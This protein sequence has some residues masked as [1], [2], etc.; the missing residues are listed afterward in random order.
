MTSK[1][2]ANLWIP[3]RKPSAHIR[4]RLFCFPYAG[5][6]A[7]VFRNWFN[8]FPSEIDICP[9]QYPGREQRMNESQFTSLP[10]LVDTL[11]EALLPELDIPFAFFG[12]SLG[13]LISFELA[14]LLQKK[15]ITPINLFLSSYRAPTIQDKE[16]PSYL[17]PDCEFVEKL[18]KNNGTPASVL[19]NRE[20]MNL[21]LPTI[22]GDFSI[23]E[24]YVYLPS[25]PLN[26]PI[27]AFGGIE[28]PDV[29]YDDL[30]LWQ[31]QT[32][33]SFSVCMF[34]G[35]H[36]YIRNNPG[37]IINLI[38]KKLLTNRDSWQ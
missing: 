31:E 34:P 10:P 7:S 19:E 5:G 16:A 25:V 26:C 15:G 20:L 32:I 33:N 27:S 1:K 28:D 35:D 2:V 21:L 36:F 24:T 8:F 22:R 17:L 13:A 6:S 3:Y 29:K 12:H 37:S 38:F 11:A 9:I 14:R 23:S 4:L 30:K 18:Y